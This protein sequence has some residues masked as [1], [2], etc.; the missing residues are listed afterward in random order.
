MLVFDDLTQEG[1]LVSHKMFPFEKIHLIMEKIAKYH[2]L[3][4]VLA[5]S[6][7]GDL[8][9]YESIFKADKMRP[10]FTELTRNVRILCDKVKTWPGFEVIGGK[11]EKIYESLFDMYVACYTT[12]NTEGFSVL[13]HGDFHIRNLMFKKNDQ[14]DLNAVLFLDFQAPVYNSPALDLIYMFNAMGAADVRE[15]R[16]EVLKMYHE[17][18]VE[19]LKSYG[20]KGTI[21][22]LD[23]VHQALL[24]KYRM[25]AYG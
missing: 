18:L 5:D 8:V 3:S 21:P 25:G 17:F 12:S 9:R 16:P 24:R 2:A 11:I 10:L 19:N 20:F 6:E 4:M 14:G 23:E 1:Y 15:R 22:T 13:N 7:Q